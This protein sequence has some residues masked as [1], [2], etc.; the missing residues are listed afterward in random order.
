LKVVWL[1]NDRQFEKALELLQETDNSLKGGEKKKTKEEII[2]YL[3]A[4]PSSPS[5]SS[6]EFVFTLYQ[7]ILFGIKFPQ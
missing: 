3:L 2:S 7:L 6:D 4:Q 5:E 1:I